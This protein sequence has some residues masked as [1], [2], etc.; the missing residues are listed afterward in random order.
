M[1]GRCATRSLCCELVCVSVLDLMLML[2]TG[3]RKQC[4]PSVASPPPG[5]LALFVL[6][7][8]VCASR[9]SFS[10]LH[11]LCLHFLGVGIHKWDCLVQ[12]PEDEH[13]RANGSAQKRLL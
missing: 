5:L 2:R 1:N 4:H 3:G 6:A 13:G 10:L 11:L 8:P 12:V 9:L 7:M